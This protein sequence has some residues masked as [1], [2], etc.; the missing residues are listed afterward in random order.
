[1]RIHTALK[2]LAIAVFFPIVASAAKTKKYRAIGFFHGNVETP[3]GKFSKMI[4][5]HGT[6][7]QS[8]LLL[9]DGPIQDSL[10]GTY[11]EIEFETAENCIFKCQGTLLKRGEAIFPPDVRGNP[12]LAKPALISPR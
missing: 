6:T 4:L 10:A 12:L 8:P 3:Q 2:I 9:K 11:F 5:R 1:M 7:A